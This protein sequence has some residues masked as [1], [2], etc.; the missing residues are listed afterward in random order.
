M[1]T[2]GVVAAYPRPTCTADRRHQPL[3]GGAPCII[4]PN[5]TTSPTCRQYGKVGTYNQPT[6]TTSTSTASRWRRN[7][8]GVSVGAELSYRQ[9]MPLL[10][11]P[12]HGAAGA[13]GSDLARVD[14]DDGGADAAAR[15]ARSAT[16][17]H[18]L[19]N[20]RRHHSQDRAVRHRDAV[21]RA[22]VDAVG[23]GHPERG[24]VQ[25]TQSTLHRRSTRSRRTTS[26]SRST[27]RRPG[28]RCSRA[29]TCSAPMTWSQGISGNA[30]V[31]LG[32]NEG[33][34]NWSAGV[35]ADIYQKYKVS[36]CKY[37]GY[38]GNYST[39]RRPAR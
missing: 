20:A 8:A 23:E 7:I 35:A 36:I 26:A 15:R 13:V 21:G 28:S 25:G 5:A 19:V 31:A 27:S 30:A 11:D 10:S 16:P 37:N 24:G 38:Y 29:S 22:D 34:G 17:M 18:G 32:G 2:P 3:P 6:A 33:A 1:P 9:N 39:D 14:R 4:N 12:V